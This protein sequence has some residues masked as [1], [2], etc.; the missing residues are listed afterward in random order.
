MQTPVGR[1]QTPV[2]KINSFATFDGTPHSNLNDRLQFES[3]LNNYLMQRNSNIQRIPPVG[4]QQM[5]VFSIFHLVIQEG[6]FEAVL[7]H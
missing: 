2:G 5:D 4:Q 6:G 7:K 1:S 3:V